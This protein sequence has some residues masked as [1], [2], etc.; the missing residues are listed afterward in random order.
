MGIA[1]DHGSTKPAWRLTIGV[2][3]ALSSGQAR[4]TPTGRIAAAGCSA[5]YRPLSRSA[6]SPIRMQ[7]R[8]GRR[9]RAT[10]TT[11]VRLAAWLVDLLTFTPHA[12][13]LS[14]FR[15]IALAVPPWPKIG[16]PLSLETNELAIALTPTS[17]ERRL[18]DHGAGRRLC[19]GP[20]APR[21]I[22]NLCAGSSRPGG[23]HRLSRSLQVAA[24]AS[25]SRAAARGEPR[26]AFILAQ[27]GLPPILSPP[28]CSLGP[29]G[30]TGRPE[31]PGDAHPAHTGACPWRLVWLP[32]DR[33]WFLAAFRSDI[34]AM[35][36]R[37]AIF[38]IVLVMIVVVGCQCA[39][40]NPRSK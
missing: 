38:E 4:P 25:G 30:Q 31:D 17:A 39:S 10:S 22:A 12:R 1:D 14:C 8:M 24:A 32:P 21:G 36:S 26:Q 40:R 35:A 15:V 33:S 37:D 28:P 13:T 3:S 19:R 7:I 18:G 23:A 5:S 9:E 16:K 29:I 27:I 34:A 20:L 2:S 6:R 11:P